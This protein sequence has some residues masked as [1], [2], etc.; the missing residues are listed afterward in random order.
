M[1]AP[2]AD[3]IVLITILLLLVA[4]DLLAHL[5]VSDAACS[6]LTSPGLYAPT[7]L[8]GALVGFAELVSRYRD[9]PWRVAMMPPGL[10][11]IGLNALAAA[12]TLFL[13]NEFPAQLHA[14]DHPVMKVIIAGTG[15]MVVVR[16]KLFTIRQPGGT[17]VAVGPAFI[18]D[19]LLS[20]INREVDRRRAQQRMTS[21]AARA[22][23]LS[24]ASYASAH[25]FL[26]ASLG[27][28]QN[29]DADVSQKL[30][31]DL[32]RL[33]D[34][35]Q[36]KALP[37]EVKFL[38]AGYSILTEFGDRAFDVVFSSLEK[39]LKIKT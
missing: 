13:L 17:D 29:L 38:I 9:A 24:A 30:R 35:A 10:V 22:A 39:Y 18:L 36:L 28:F 20:A 31:D 14:P 5:R 3:R 23:A 8:I 27:A 21:V 32:R 33:V 34:D 37:D 16:T 19:T 11:F 26:M 1:D 2:P 12:L 7:A 4:A 6:W 25:D 15:A